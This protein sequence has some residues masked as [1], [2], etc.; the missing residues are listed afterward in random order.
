MAGVGPG[1]IGD[2][3]KASLNSYIHAYLIDEGLLD[4]A[5]SFKTNS[6]AQFN[7]DLISRASTRRQNG[8]DAEDSRDEANNRMKAQGNA[9]G[10]IALFD[11]WCIYWDLHS[12]STR[13]ATTNYLNAQTQ[14]SYAAE[15]HEVARGGFMS[16]E[17]YF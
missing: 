5:N 3:Y 6:G 2:D 14:V 17:E 7:E 4:I 16:P 8:G 12:G 13:G 9:T 10:D 11:W 15:L 1:A